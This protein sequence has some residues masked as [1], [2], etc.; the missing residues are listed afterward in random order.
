MKVSDG[1]FR[2]PLGRR[3]KDIGGISHGCAC[4]VPF[5][6]D[7]RRTRPPYAND[8][9]NHVFPISQLNCSERTC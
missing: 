1:T 2:L 7:R 3:E 8:F 6:W 9:A 5:D 4:P